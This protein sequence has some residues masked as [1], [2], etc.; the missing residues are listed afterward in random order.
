M[1][2]FGHAM[3]LIPSFHGVRQKR[4]GAW[5]PFCV[6]NTKKNGLQIMSLAAYASETND[7][8]NTDWEQIPPPIRDLA[9]ILLNQSYWAL[10]IYFFLLCTMLIEV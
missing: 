1:R 9:I 6:L 10:F 8:N 2:G 7:N 4:L 3:F 5:L